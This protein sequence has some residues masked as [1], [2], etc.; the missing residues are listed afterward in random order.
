MPLLFQLVRFAVIDVIESY[1][2]LAAVGSA[3]RELH[4]ERKFR[5]L[6]EKRHL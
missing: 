4:P 2:T 5:L 3:T 6:V 1:V